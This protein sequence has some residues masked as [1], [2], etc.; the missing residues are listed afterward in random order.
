M[1]TRTSPSFETARER[2]F[3]SRMAILLVILMFAGFA[4]SF[5]LKGL[6]PAYPRPNPTLSPWVILH[7]V[8][9][10]LWMLAFVAQT[11][12]VAARRVDLHM[13][14]GKAAMLVAIAIV[15]LMYLVAVW[16]VGRANQPPFTDPLNWTIVPL[17]DI[18]A[19][20]LLVLTGWLKRR[21]PQWHKRAMLAAAIFVVMGPAI[22]RLPIAPPNFAGFT[23]VL[24]IGL[25]LFAPMFW[26][27]RRSLGQVHP[28]TWMGFGLAAGVTAA[29]LAILYSGRWEPIARQLPGVSA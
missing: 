15:P 19:Y 8:L 28:A 20:A 21:Q 23:F 3:Y 18:P 17:L 9:F 16:Q 25:L 26:W 11:Q 27:D 13:K 4:P 22:A 6:V 5:Y 12:L 10:T 14:L 7:G 1:A 2:R 29:R 24:L